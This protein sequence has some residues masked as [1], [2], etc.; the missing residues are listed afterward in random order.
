M[1]VMACSDIA[2]D[3]RVDP[4]TS[5]MIVRQVCDL[6]F[7]SRGNFVRVFADKFSAAIVDKDRFLGQ[8][9]VC[10]SSLFYPLPV[11]VVKIFTNSSR[12]RFATKRFDFD[13]LVLGVVRELSVLGVSSR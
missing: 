11:A 3:I 5:K 12:Y 13:L 8:D 7:L 2:V 1:I 4:R 6:R 9:V 10:I